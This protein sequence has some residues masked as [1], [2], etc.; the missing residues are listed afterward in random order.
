MNPFRCF[1]RNRLALDAATGKRRWHFQFVHHDLWD[2]DLPAP[3]N[4]VTIRQ[5]RLARGARPAVAAQ[6]LLDVGQG[7][8]RNRPFSWADEETG[9]GAFK[10]CQV[11]R[12]AGIGRLGLKKLIRDFA[13]RHRGRGFPVHDNEV[14]GIAKAPTRFGQR[15]KGVNDSSALTLIQGRPE[16]AIVGH[17]RPPFP[18][19]GFRL[20]QLREELPFPR[21]P[22]NSGRDTHDERE[23]SVLG[24]RTDFEARIH[25]VE[26]GAQRRP[27]DRAKRG[28]TR[29]NRGKAR[30][31]L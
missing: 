17:F 25:G 26:T 19:E 16:G 22:E 30:W 6:K 14:R 10:L 1:V 23:L 15:V 13:E 7:D 5:T 3:A 27:S 12:P 4:L 28:E 8:F 18:D 11:T 21:S 20:S 31:A 2:R 24:H 9:N 29:A